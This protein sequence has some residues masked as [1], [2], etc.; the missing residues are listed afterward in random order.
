[1]SRNKRDVKCE[2]HLQFNV[3][4][5]SMRLRPTRHTGLY[6]TARATSHHLGISQILNIHYLHMRSAMARAR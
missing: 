6:K 5:I 2:F 3:N 4:L 1:V